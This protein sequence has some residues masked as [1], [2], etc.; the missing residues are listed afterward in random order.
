MK[1]IVE[2]NEF[3]CY[4]YVESEKH[5]KVVEPKRAKE[6]GIIRRRLSDLNEECN[7]DHFPNSYFVFNITK[8]QPRFPR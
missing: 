6:A 7:L 5:Y 3:G 2:N 4:A 8:K 1:L